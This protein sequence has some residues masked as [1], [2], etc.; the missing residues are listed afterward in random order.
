MTTQQTAIEALVKQGCKLP[1]ETDSKGVIVLTIPDERVFNDYY[2]KIE[3]DV[4]WALHCGYTF[5]PERL[6]FTIKNSVQQRDF[7]VSDFVEVY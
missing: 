1:I 6:Y 3:R 4:R 5:R 7:S 2:K